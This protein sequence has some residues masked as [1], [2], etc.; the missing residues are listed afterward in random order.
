MGVS[1]SS[2]VAI[3]DISFVTTGCETLPPQA[4]KFS[5]DGEN[6]A[7]SIVPSFLATVVSFL[8]SKFIF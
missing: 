6:S 2:D 7:G 1:G 3:D 4:D 5:A 8:I